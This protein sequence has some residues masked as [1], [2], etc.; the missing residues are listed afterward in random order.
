MEEDIK[1]NQPQENTQNSN[2]NESIFK[3][4]ISVIWEFL[5][6]VII[7]AVI[8]LPIRYFLFQPFIVSGDSMV[9]NFH[10]GDYLIIDEFSYR[11]KDP[12]RG[13]VVVLKY[14]LDNKQR[15][16]KRIIGLPGET[17]N[18][19]NGR[20]TILKNDTSLVLDEKKYLPDV[21]F[22]D[23]NIHLV[24]DENKYFVMGDNRQ[25]SYDSRRWGVLPK[26]DI[27]GRAA[28]RLLPISAISF[29]SDPSY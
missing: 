6:I 28:F 19:E 23:G 4:Y 9:P 2:G 29:I 3:K 1:I 15:F 25:F 22:T 10:S 12:Q 24:L 26:E 7:A 13:D 18:I 21:L 14:P 11:F 27:I 20:V 16:I 8:V 17:V 5:K